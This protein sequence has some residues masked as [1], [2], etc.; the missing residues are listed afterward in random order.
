ME[1]I[2][3]LSAYRITV[4]LHCLIRWVGLEIEHELGLAGAD[5][6]KQRRLS[7]GITRVEIVIQPRAKETNG[8]GRHG[9]CD[10]QAFTECVTPADEA[11]A[12]AWR[13][14]RP[15]LHDS[16]PDESLT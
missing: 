5:V 10:R 1:P 2:H 8:R 11:V 9:P 6:Q 4:V 3:T 12:A 16:A 15:A 7:A 13:A 14:R